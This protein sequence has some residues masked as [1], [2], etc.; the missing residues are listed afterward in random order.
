MSVQPCGA[1]DQSGCGGMTPPTE[2]EK[3]GRSV[4]GR[5]VRGTSRAK[6]RWTCNVGLRSVWHCP[7]KQTEKRHSSKSVSVHVFRRSSSPEGPMEGG[8]SSDGANAPKERADGNSAENG[9]PETAQS[10]AVGSGGPSLLLGSSSDSP[11][12]AT[13]PYG[14]LRWQE[15]RRIWTG[16]ADPSRPGSSPQS[17]SGRSRAKRS[18]LEM[19][20]LC[21]CLVQPESSLP[22][23]VNLADMVGILLELWE[24]EGLFD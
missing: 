23:R 11:S 6:G 20:K 22:Q 15:M 14:F 18:N 10:P 8:M 24:G 9:P 5:S 4:W 1:A 21:E 13:P 3:E 17:P 16:Q 12:P 2:E 19:D 7:K